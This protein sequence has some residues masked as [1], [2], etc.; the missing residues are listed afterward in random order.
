MNTEGYDPVTPNLRYCLYIL[1]GNIKATW[2]YVSPPPLY[3]EQFFCHHLHIEPLKRGQHANG[4]AFR[5]SNR[6]NRLMVM[7]SCTVWF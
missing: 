2:L 4:H 1:I 5:T 7:I 3:L 6:I